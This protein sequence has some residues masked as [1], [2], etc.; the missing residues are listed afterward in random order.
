MNGRI[1]SDE[2]FRH[3]RGADALLLLIGDTHRTALSA[4][5]FDYLLA[6]RPILGTGPS[7]ATAEELINTCGVGQWIDGGAEGRPDLIAALRQVEA[8]ALSY[9]PQ[10][11]E[12][13]RYSAD[14]MASAT[15]RMLDAVDSRQ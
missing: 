6:A 2:V 7:G 8:R 11:D 5:V 9:A 10:A 12:I 14:G 1:P 4:K 15:V 3:M 13:R